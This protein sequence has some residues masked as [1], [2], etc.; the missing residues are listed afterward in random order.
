M[1]D[2]ICKVTLC[3][4]SVHLLFWKEL[5]RRCEEDFLFGQKWT[6][7]VLVGEDRKLNPLV[8]STEV[9]PGFSYLPAD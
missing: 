2:P 8:R 9:L 5:E 1:A 3:H 7:V 6:L 4:Q